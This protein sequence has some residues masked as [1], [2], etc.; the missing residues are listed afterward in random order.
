M[1]E[2]FPLKETKSVLYSSVLDTGVEEVGEGE[3]V[4]I[5]FALSFHRAL[6]RTTTHARYKTLLLSINCL[7]NNDQELVGTTALG[8][9]L[10]SILRDCFKIVIC[11][12]TKE[13]YVVR[14]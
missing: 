1:R 8:Q 5:K 11:S 4:R 9:P 6:F 14:G 2:K 13:L 12:C 3:G 7:E 10:S